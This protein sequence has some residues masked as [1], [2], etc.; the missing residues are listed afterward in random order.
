M[1]FNVM[2]LGLT[3]AILWALLVLLVGIINLIFPGYGVAFLKIVDS[4]YPGY[5]F[6]KW[7]FGGVIVA[8][9][10][11]VIDGFVV[12]VVIA[13]LYNLLGKRMKKEV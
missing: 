2:Q 3:L 9:L 10:Y 12:G 1:K 6:A 7:G 11:A 4:I 5:H 13:W 8:T